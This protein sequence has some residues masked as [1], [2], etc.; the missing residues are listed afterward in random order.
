MEAVGL[1]FRQRRVQHTV[2]FASDSDPQ[3]RQ[4]L[5]ANHAPRVLLKD[6]DELGPEEKPHCDIYSAG[7]PRGP[8]SPAGL[9][10]GVDD[11]M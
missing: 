2:A 3:A 10:Q 8:F 6:A 5:Q 1:V 4:F 9:R 7:A 11:I